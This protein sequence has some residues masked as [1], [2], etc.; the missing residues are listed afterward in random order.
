MCDINMTTFELTVLGWGSRIFQGITPLMGWVD[1]TLSELQPYCYT[2]TETYKCLV[3][4]LLV[5]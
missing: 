2:S 4:R 3:C 5:L 1:K